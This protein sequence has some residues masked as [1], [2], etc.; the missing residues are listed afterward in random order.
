MGYFQI[1]NTNFSFSEQSFLSNKL[2]RFINYYDFL[3]FECNT[4]H[5]ISGNEKSLARQEEHMEKKYP[6]FSKCILFGG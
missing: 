3:S 5:V 2:I 4:F 6:K 1:T